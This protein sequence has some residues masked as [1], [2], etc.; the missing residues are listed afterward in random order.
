MRSRRK[1]L[2]RKWKAPRQRQRALRRRAR[3]GRCS[4]PPMDGKVIPVTEI[5][6]QVFSQKILGDGVGIDPTGDTVYAPADGTVSVVAEDTGHSCGLTL[7]GG[8]EVLIHVGIDTVEMQGDG[9]ELLVKVGDTVRRGDALLRFSS[10][11]IKAA[12][13]STISAFVVADPAQASSMVFHTGMQ[14]EACKTPVADFE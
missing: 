4:F 3:T 10:D 12:G 8:M 1:A 7:E 6:D 2:R 11:K 5:P 14:A 9:F 13:H